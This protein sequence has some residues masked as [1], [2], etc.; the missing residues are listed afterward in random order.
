MNLPKV[1][2]VS[3]RKIGKL[4]FMRKIFYLFVATSL[5]GLLSL[6]SVQAQEA[7]ETSDE[8]PLLL[9]HYM[10]WYQTPEV[11][12][13]W[14]WHWT[15]DHFNPEQ[16]D[17]NG[18]PEIASQFMPLTGPYDS[19][20]EDVLEYQVLLMKL[21]GIDGV[22]VD[23]YGTANYADYPAINDSTNALFEYTKKAGLNF[24]ICYE[25]R[26]LMAMTG[27]NVLDSEEANVQAKEDIEYA[28]ETWFRDKSYT[29]FSEQPLLFTFGPLYFRTPD[30]WEGIFADLEAPP[31][32]VTLD[33][34]LDWWAL[35]SYPWPP[36][37][38]S[39]GIE[40]LPAVLESYL[41]LFYRNARRRDLIVG[42]AFPGFFDI[43]EEAGVRTSYGH[44][45]A[46]NGE[47]M[48][49]T[50]EKALESEADI[51]QL[52]TWNDYGE[53]TNIEPTEET[54]YSYLE[55][56]QQQRREMD[57]IFTFTSEDLTLP[58]EIFNLRKANPDDAEINAQLDAAFDAI[59]AGNVEDA[60]AILAEL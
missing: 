32:M 52:V 57:E 49:M 29:R 51:I 42:S 39:G 19:Q 47:T 28:A 26:T 36:M 44:I 35:S 2:I 9:A 24:T 16:T 53:G 33:G 55:Y 10:P 56:I 23:W 3:I 17:E 48:R 40:M 50:F 21:S 59:V 11:S 22:I 12:G 20:D 1:S 13:V 31:A 25:D 30:D 14:G 5:I 15:M 27:A 8:R 45:P 54:G 18:N 46:N 58:L 43:Y 38:R 6:S 60:R 34:Y 37:E 41:D 4:T 7:D